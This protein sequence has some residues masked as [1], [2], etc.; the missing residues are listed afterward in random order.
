MAGRI[1]SG[2]N[3]ITAATSGPG[4]GQPSVTLTSGY[5][6]QHS[7]TSVSDN[8]SGNVGLTTYLYDAGQRLTTITTSYGGTAGPQVVTS[9]AA[10]N[11]ISA[12]SRT[13]GGSGT[14][15]NTSYS[16]D[17]SDRQTTITDYVPG[18]GGSALATYVYSYD[19]SSR[20]TTMVD[21]EGTYTYTYDNSDELT[22]V[23]KG[24]VQ[25]ESYA[26]DAN[27]NRTGTGYS[28]TVMN[29]T[30][31]SPGVITYTYLCSGQP[32][33]AD[34]FQISGRRVAPSVGHSR[35]KAA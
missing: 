16:Y 29:E 27:G 22:N 14:A 24:G 1:R 3:E 23:D 15:V 17:A 26:Y 35:L 5:N 31:T 6:A 18:S 10:N 33:L 21:A 25:V 30:L 12:Q 8:V 20:V 2:G 4:T 28:T 34:F 13:I 7:L 11:Q 32:Q 9:Y 19:K